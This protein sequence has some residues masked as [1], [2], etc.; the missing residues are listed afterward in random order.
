MSIAG[1]EVRLVPADEAAG[2]SELLAAHHYLGPRGSGRLLRYAACLDGEPVVL[3]TFG[4]AAWKC[5]PREEFLG[6]DDEQRAARLGAIAGNQRLCVL[7]AGRRPNL[8]SAALGAMLRRL[9]ADYLAA[10]GRPVAAVETF[11]DPARG[12]GSVYAAA[13][14]TPA[15]LTAGYGRV[16]GQSG[17]AFHG[18]R[19]QYW[20]RG[21][22]PA[23][24]AGLP[25]LLSAPF[26]SPLITPGGKGRPD[27]NA[28][29]ISGGGT[30]GGGDCLS[31]LEHLRAVTDHRQARGKRHPLEAI[32][33][34]IAVAKLC[35]ANSVYAVGQY[36]AG[37]PQQALRRCGLRRNQRTGRCHPPSLKT[38]KRAIKSIDAAQA[39][40]A[41]CAWLRQEAAAGRASRRHLAVDGKS[42]N[43]ARDKN[44][45]AP[46]LLAAYDVTTGTVAA[47]LDVNAKHNEITYFAD[48][49]ACLDT[50]G[51]G[52]DRDDR[53]GN[54]GGDEDEPFT[55]IT[56][57][58]LHTQTAH[59]KAMN[60]AG[61]DWMLTVKGNQASLED[62]ICS[63]DWDS[64]PPSAHH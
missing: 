3:A 48:L 46:H 7:P 45:N 22:G 32:L 1:L 19:K 34:V 18:D 57:D 5:R 10:S 21:L 64:I 43:G 59:V 62:E 24:A 15:G 50:P 26:D 41:I 39:D 31:L 12:S 23:P 44:G 30:G 13:G 47:Q 53:G 54:D 17:Y 49:L 51:A 52:D 2:F 29:N 14:F 63:F 36:A 4:S 38:I 58:A 33:V 60:A 6:W 55:L 27:L 40:A 56:A 28:M 16:R 11:T 37:M 42:V 8:A 25:G 61:L 35:G 20:L 9:P